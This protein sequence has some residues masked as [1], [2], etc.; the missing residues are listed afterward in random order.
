ML[1]QQLYLNGRCC[2]AVEL[3]QKAFDAKTDS[4][5]FDPRKE[6]DKYVIH[7]E[8]HILGTRINLPCYRIITYKRWQDDRI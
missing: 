3:Y 5:M 1:V 8:M 7:A 2:E 6:P 4:I